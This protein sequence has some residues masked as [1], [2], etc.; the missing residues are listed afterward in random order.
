M[1]YID[2]DDL[3]LPEGWEDRAQQ[4]LEEVRGLQLSQRKQAI[5]ARSVIWRDLKEALKKLSHGKC[6][7]C[8]TRQ[9]RSDNTVDH[10]RPKNKVAQCANHE[11]YWWLAFDWHNYRFSCTYCNSRRKDQDGGSGGKQDH[12]PLLDEEKRAYSDQDDLDVE[13]P[14]LLDPARATDPRLIWFREDGQAA[15]RYSEDERPI[16]YQRADVSIRLYHLNYTDT[17]ERRRVL[18]RE[19]KRL[20]KNGDK[21]FD[22]L[23]DGDQVDDLADDSLDK[24]MRDLAKMVGESAEFS[25]TARVYLLGFRDHAW[26][27]G[28]LATF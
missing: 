4:A 3:K 14:C 22:R 27:E 5:N 16:S 18:Y 20:V 12:F 23:E 6:W 7:Y 8:E 1:R 9:E 28:V 10:F 11:G 19:V 2:L 17:M 24:V 25:A 13:R 26:V 15:P 21:C